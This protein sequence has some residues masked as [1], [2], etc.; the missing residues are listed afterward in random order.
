MVRTGLSESVG[1]TASSHSSRSTSSE[2]PNSSMVSCKYKTVLCARAPLAPIVDEQFLRHET[3]RMRYLD[4]LRI[5]KRKSVRLRQ[6]D[7]PRRTQQH[8]D[9]AQVL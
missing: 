7:L 2:T 6:F 8:V 1:F 9:V 5:F 4:L 3:S